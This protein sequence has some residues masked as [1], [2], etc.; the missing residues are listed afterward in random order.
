MMHPLFPHVDFPPPPGVSLSADWTM[1][2]HGRLCIDYLVDDPA[3]RIRWP[4]RGSGRTDGL[5]RH[6]CLEAF[7]ASAATPAYLEFNLTR[8]GAWAAYAFDAYR[9]G[10]RD[11]TLDQAPQIVSDA[12]G[13]ST[14][15]LDLAAIDVQI[16]P[17]PWRLAITA[18]IEARDG[19]TSYWSLA[20]PQGKPD[21]HHAD[22]F[23]AQ[24]G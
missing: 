2:E 14:V 4:D 20:H 19:S 9:A 5:W 15:T 10:M 23:A 24:L 7:I 8:S 16:G 21:F 17:A 18:V 1:D 12:T 11:F 3:C 6:S 13:V 22:C